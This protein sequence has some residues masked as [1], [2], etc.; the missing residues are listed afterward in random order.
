MFAFGAVPFEPGASRHGFHSKGRPGRQANG[1]LGCPPPWGL[2]GC[3]MFSL[4][5]HLRVPPFASGPSSG[6]VHTRPHPCT[7]GGRVSLGQCPFLPASQGRAAP[8]ASAGRTGRRFLLFS[9]GSLVPAL[10]DSPTPQPP[11]GEG[12]RC[13]GLLG[14]P[15]CAHAHHP[16]DRQAPTSAKQ[17][18]G[19]GAQGA[20]KNGGGHRAPP[21]PQSLPHFQTS[22][23]QTSV[24]LASVS[25][26]HLAWEKPPFEDQGRHPVD[27]AS[28]PS[29]TADPPLCG[30]WLGPLATLS[31]PPTPT[32]SG[33]ALPITCEFQ[34]FLAGTG[35]GAFWNSTVFSAPNQALSPPARASPTLLGPASSCHPL[36]P[37]STNPPWAGE[38]PPRCPV[39]A[40]RS[41]SKAPS[42]P[43]GPDDILHR[44]QRH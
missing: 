6:P 26:R 44:R 24:W 15:P 5:L 35:A 29:W 7:R 14:T 12:S 40:S 43:R 9:A 20:R 37:G 41:E 28:V 34:A 39:C 22:T 33:T 25:R 31:V 42:L 3:G 21:A 16:A 23:R 30:G 1:I 17:G 8:E 10:V 18:T 4:R 2:W 13:G 36:C 27:G 11:C 19:E 38:P 32:G